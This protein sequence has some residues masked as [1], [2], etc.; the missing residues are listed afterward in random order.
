M[1]EDYIVD[2]NLY[3]ITTSLGEMFRVCGR[4]HNIRDIGKVCFV[5]LRD[6]LRTLQCV[7]I[8]KKNPELYSKIQTLTKESFVVVIG[9]LSKL[10][11]K[12]ARVES[13]FYKDFELNIS[14]IE[15][16]NL[17]HSLPIE[18]DNANQLYA[19]IKDSMDTNDRG[20]IGLHT[21]LNN[22]VLELRAPMNWTI[23][24]LQSVVVG[25]FEEY[26]KSLDFIGIKT[27]KTIGTSS[28]SG[29]SVFKVQYFN[30]QGYLAQSPQLYKQ[31]AIN[32]DL[33]RVYEIGPVFRAENSVSHRHL[34]EFV[35]MD[36]EMAL[37]YPFNYTEI[38]NV[39]WGALVNIFSTLE[40][41][42][43]EESEYLR[44]IT[45]TDKLMYTVEPKIIT[46]TEGFKMLNDSGF[47]QSDNDDLTTENE[48]NLGDLIK[49]LYDTDIFILTEY[50]Q[51]CR[52]FYTMQKAGTSFSYSFDVIMRG[53]EICSG[54]QRIHQYETL[55]S[56]LKELGIPEEPFE[57]YLTSFKYGSRPHGGCG[58]GLERILMLYYSL[59]N[60]R[61]T[62]MFPR[63]PS[64]LTP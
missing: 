33:N 20:S 27:P 22:R 19:E 55:I 41:D 62:S 10:P 30:K 1:S 42:Y 2:T 24:K 54:A 26:L 14:D 37:S 61:V 45:K 36:I 59:A 9:K 28:E 39:L 53:E 15:I 57:D 11:P 5:I 12:V 49:T 4:V 60:V 50:P 16:I 8:P 56:R 7:M 23:F 44:S 43:C 35:G 64:R 46:F 38:L 51:T 13:C 29:A 32:A 48:K 21:R 3:N 17:S 6:R 40:R 63:D 31:M 25:A 18:I 47:T 58:F 52:P 34:C